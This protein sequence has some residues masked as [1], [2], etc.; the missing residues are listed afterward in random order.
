MAKVAKQV[1][2]VGS[3]ALLPDCHT[4]DAP[5]EEVA[6]FLAEQEGGEAVALCSKSNVGDS[7]ALPHAAE[8]VVRVLRGNRRR[9]SCTYR[10]L[11]VLDCFARLLS[12]GRPG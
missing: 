3:M 1:P 9:F 11:V 4:S 5:D 12:W 2:C 7:H 8:G 6:A 10:S